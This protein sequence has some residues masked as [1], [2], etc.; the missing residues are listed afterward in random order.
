MTSINGM[1]RS[2]FVQSVGTLVGGRKAGEIF[3]QAVANPARPT[4]DTF[5]S[6]PNRW[7]GT[8]GISPQENRY[9]SSLSPKERARHLMM[10]RILNSPPSQKFT[11][12]EEMLM[13]MS[14]PK[15]RAAF[16]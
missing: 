2:H 16:C 6:D 10:K 1:S 14:D 5:L 4:P 12:E 9:L 15:D 8:A 7:L 11:P 3:D 13:G